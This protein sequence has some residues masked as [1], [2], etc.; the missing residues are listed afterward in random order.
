MKKSRLIT[1]LLLLP[2]LA[3]CAKNPA[4]GNQDFVM[5]SES[6]ELKVGQQ[7]FN[8][9]RKNM[10]LLPEND[11][12]AQYVDRVGQKIAATADR[13]DL[14]FRFYVVDDDTINAFA[15]P[16]GYI[17]I[18]RGLINHLN[19]EA[20]LAAVLGHEA[21]H[22]TAR[23]SVQQI[24][25]AR[26]YQTAMMVTSIF[27]P[28]PQA[29]GMLSDVMATAILKGYGR[30]AELQS[31][32]LSI[33]YLA[34]AGYDPHATIG[35]LKTLKRLND[36]STKEKTDAGETVENYHGAFASHPETSKRIEEA[37]AQAATLEGHSGGIVNHDAML[38]A[39]DGYPYGDSEQQG[40]VVGRR[41]L[42][43]EL[44]IQLTFPKDWVIT[45]SPQAL[46]ARLR[47]EKVFFMLGM[48][49]M[50]KRQ[51][52][53]EIIKEMFTDRHIQNLESSVRN[54]MPYAHAQIKESAPKV[55][56]AMIDAHIFLR[57]RKAFANSMWSE[58]DQFDKYKAQFEQIANSFGDYNKERDGDI[59]RIELHKWQAGDSWQKLAGK[60]NNILGRFTADKIAA[61]NGM[62]LTE[63]PAAGQL[64]KSVK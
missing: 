11:P 47:Q 61:L 52:P 15:L 50:Q 32:E 28:I 51:T 26:A 54:G 59:P 37:I 44:G 9:M 13:K 5:M 30:D 63:S 57:E 2:L 24:S 60:R 36:I 8:E 38:A 14:F 25:K 29:A 19:N 6:E 21:G 58:R 43:P 49:E 64:I 20:E 10:V 1:L 4:T 12:L 41:F 16:G 3:A 22:V 39:V 48:K 53:E 31:D 23:H 7:V 40:A 34:R 55:S 33:R 42:H 27:V 56:K 62:D 17:F 18:H 46:T 35:I 45:N